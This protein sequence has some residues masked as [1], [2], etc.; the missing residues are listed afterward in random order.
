MPRAEPGALGTPLLDQSAEAPP[1]KQKE[2]NVEDRGGSRDGAHESAEEPEPEPEQGPAQHVP[3]HVQAAVAGAKSQEGGLEPESGGQ[4]WEEERGSEAAVH[5]NIQ[6]WFDRQLTFYGYQLQGPDTKCSTCCIWARGLLVVQVVFAFGSVLDTFVLK[7]DLLVDVVESDPRHEVGANHTQHDHF[8][9]FE[10]GTSTALVLLQVMDR[11]LVWRA[12]S[13]V[14]PWPC[15]ARRQSPTTVD[16]QTSAD[17]KLMRWLC[18]CLWVPTVCCMGG[19]WVLDVHHGIVKNFQ[20]GLVLGLVELCEYI[21]PVTTL[22]ATMLVIQAQ[23]QNHTDRLQRQ[24]I[25]S[26]ADA[27]TTLQI[28]LVEEQKIGST[29]KEWQL[30]LVLEALIF[31]FMLSNQVAWTLDPSSQFNWLLARCFAGFSFWPL[32]LSVY[33]VVEFN[34]FVDSIPAQLTRGKRFGLERG[35]FIADLERLKLGIKVYG[36]R[37][38]RGDIIKAFFSVVGTIL[39]ALANKWL[40]EE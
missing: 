36:V 15:Q 5:M 35:D 9:G 26:T 28:L 4:D 25:D 38:V 39:A 23:C 22:G 21:V 31:L 1:V 18:L 6:P 16:E 19:V 27:A 30:V 29:S 14:W 32:A 37:I 7:G 33:G 17:D 10:K 3:F 12:A 20:D 34:H 2:G 8:A 40:R 13:G 11:I 24:V